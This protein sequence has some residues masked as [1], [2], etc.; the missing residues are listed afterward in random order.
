MSEDTSLTNAVKLAA[1][2][3]LTEAVKDVAGRRAWLVDEV[4]EHRDDAARARARR[5]ATR[6]SPHARRLAA[7]RH[8]RI[9]CS[10]G[11]R[12]STVLDG[13]RGLPAGRAQARRARHR[14]FRLPAHAQA[15][16]PQER[17]DRHGR[18]AEEARLSR[19]R[20]LRSR[21]GGVRREDRATS[22]RPCEARRSASSSMPGTGCRCRASNYL[23]PVDAK[24]TTVVGTRLRRWCASISCTGRWSARRRPIILFFDACRDNPLARNLTRAIGTRSAEI[25]RGLAA[26]ESG[27]GTL[28]SFSTQPGNVALDGD[29]PQFALLRRAGAAARSLAATT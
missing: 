13:P 25:G 28:I 14:Q 27:V 17:C 9:A 26:V 18:R 7:V 19:P 16:E 24:L 11:R 22:P 20:G 6:F 10:P 2:I 3:S 4:L 1:G 5:R 8:S 21:Q 23:V 29:G 12:T 15:R